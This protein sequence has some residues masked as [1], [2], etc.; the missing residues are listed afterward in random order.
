MKKIIAPVFI[1][2]ILIAAAYL[3]GV[4]TGKHRVETGRNYAGFKQ[5][6]KSAICA[7]KRSA[8]YAIDD[9][10]VFWVREGDCPDNSYS[11]ILYGSTPKDELCSV[12]D[13]FEGPRKTCRDARYK[14]IFE[15]IIDHLDKDDL[16]LGS[17][18]TV[19]K[20]L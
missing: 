6:T 4:L 13:S 3:A 14:D 11:H 20:I 7:N 12:Y 9:K 2:A 16:G 1:I 8:L 5:L 17:S 18:H 15:T 10:Y 19:R